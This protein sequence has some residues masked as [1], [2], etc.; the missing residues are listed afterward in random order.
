[1]QFKVSPSFWEV[2]PEGEISVLVLK[3]INNNPGNTDFSK[4]LEEAKMAS[5]QYLT[6]DVFS[7]N[8]VVQTWRDA[9]KKFKTKK[10]AR[11]SIEALLK[12]VDQDR[13]FTPINPLVDIYNSVSLTY[14]V[15]CGGEDLDTMKGDMILG[16]AQGG[17]SFRAL[18]DE[19]DSPALPEEIIYYDEE[20]AICRSLNWRDA[21]RTMLTEKTTHAILLMEAVDADM[22]P[23]TREAMQALQERCEVYFGVK[24]NRFEVTVSN[25]TIEI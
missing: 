12:R 11:S 1:M 21:Q 9:Y 20:G 6:E 16:K 8:A 5:K 24:G 18:G 2:F 10:G 23:K 19:A 7:Q 15:P 3:G 22:I 14:A 13:T 25:P 17:E 4:M